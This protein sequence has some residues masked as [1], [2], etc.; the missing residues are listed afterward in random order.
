VAALH[1]TERAVA[2]GRKFGVPRQ[3]ST[4]MLIASQPPG[5]FATEDGRI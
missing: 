3:I 5:S 4:P 2:S 1:A